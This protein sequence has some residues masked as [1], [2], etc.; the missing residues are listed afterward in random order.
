MLEGGGG[1][2][3]MMVS[4]RSAILKMCVCVLGRVVAVMFYSWVKTF[5][6][7]ETKNQNVKMGS[8]ARY[9]FSIRP[10]ELGCGKPGSII[11]YWNGQ[12]RGDDGGWEWPC[13]GGNSLW[14]GK[15]SLVLFSHKGTLLPGRAKEAD[16]SLL[17]S[18]EIG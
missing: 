1:E 7:W 9:I 5:E 13:V 10:E 12:E 16:W 4:A 14:G 3:G 18:C 17:E 2:L 8:A 11:G 15:C 6:C